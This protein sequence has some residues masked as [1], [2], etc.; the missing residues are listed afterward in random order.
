LSVPAEVARG[1]GCGTETARGLPHPR[2]KSGRS[3]F[4]S[5]R[6]SGCSHAQ[7]ERRA[8]GGDRGVPE[9]AGH[10]AAFR[11]RAGTARVGCPAARAHAYPVEVCSVAETAARVGPAGS[12]REAEGTHARPARGAALRRR[13]RPPRRRLA[14]RAADG[15]TRESGARRPRGAA[16]A[17]RTLRWSISSGLSADSSSCLPRSW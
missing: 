10:H 6:L 16:H 4:T 1:T 12:C 11:G 5:A 9:E 3:D 7:G 8:E 13:D 17:E 14:A 2:F 15:V